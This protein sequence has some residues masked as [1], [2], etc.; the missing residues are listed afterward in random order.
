MT[1]ATDRE[2]IDVAQSTEQ[3][4][5][6][7]STRTTKTGFDLPMLLH[8]RLA[9]SPEEYVRRYDLIQLA[10]ERDGLDA[11]LIRSPESITYFS[12]YETP[13]YYRYHCIVVPRNAEPVFVVR[14]FEWINS[15]EFAWSTKLSKV[16]DWDH[17]PEVTV[18][19]LRQLGLS[20]SRRI[21]VGE[22]VVLLHSRRA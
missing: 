7:K 8:E 6:Q 14:D 16:Y 3:V 22:A 5:F 21:G 4:T 12:G 1:F 13:G 18:S 15:P 10:M 11:L 19:V 17:S 9:F 2:I 20:S